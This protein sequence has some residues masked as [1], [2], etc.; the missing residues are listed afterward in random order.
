M[1]LG[2]ILEVMEHM[3]KEVINVLWKNKD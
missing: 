2:N 1:E 3:N